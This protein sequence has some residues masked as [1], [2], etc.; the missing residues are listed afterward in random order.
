MSSKESD[1][2]VTVKDKSLSCR[3]VKGRYKW[4][5]LLNMEMSPK[6]GEKIRRDSCGEHGITP[7]ETKSLTGGVFTI[8]TGYLIL[9][10]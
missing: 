10:A 8:V 9:I 2:E 1:V 6:Y 3:T 4:K 5:C 7:R